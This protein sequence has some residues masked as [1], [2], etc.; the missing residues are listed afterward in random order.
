[1]LGWPLQ[2][3]VK[4][5][6]TS[7]GLD[8]ATASR[9]GDMALYAAHAVNA[10]VRQS[11]KAASTWVTP[12]RLSASCSKRS[13][14]SWKGCLYSSLRC[15]PVGSE[16]CFPRCCHKSAIH[17]GMQNS[18]QLRPASNIGRSRMSPLRDECLAKCLGLHSGRFWDVV[19]L[20]EQGIAIRLA[21][22]HS[23]QWA[24]VRKHVEQQ[25]S[26]D[27]IKGPPDLAKDSRIIHAI[28]SSVNTVFALLML[29]ALQHCVI[30]AS[31]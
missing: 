6:C 14:R 26:L 22:Q 13:A 28:M 31:H 9:Y 20:Q 16:S 23:A 25:E 19:G 27:V 7:A 1:M 30:G 8:E 5:A 15:C 12:T 4:D 29:C 24:Q 21:N 18:R 17:L 2:S 10:L 11:S 3:G